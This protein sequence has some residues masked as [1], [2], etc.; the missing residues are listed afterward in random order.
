MRHGER[1]ENDADRTRPGSMGS[2][3]ASWRSAISQEL[4][5][6]EELILPQE[7]ALPQEFAR[8]QELPLSQE[9]ALGFACEGRVDRWTQRDRTIR[10]W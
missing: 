10:Y 1:D 8:S 3:A 2:E 7:L 4:I 5:L 9:L 6:P